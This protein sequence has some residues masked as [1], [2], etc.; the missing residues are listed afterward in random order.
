MIRAPASGGAPAVAD[1]LAEALRPSYE[2]RQLPLALLTA[3]FDASGHPKAQE[4]D[5]SYY[6]C[7]FVSTAAK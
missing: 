3:Y 2:P 6:V 1:E 7:G 5:A 4:L